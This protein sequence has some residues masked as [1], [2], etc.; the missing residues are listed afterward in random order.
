MP[1]SKIIVLHWLTITVALGGLVP[2]A[3]AQPPPSM[4]AQTPPSAGS[5]Q[6][7][8][9]ARPTVPLGN[10]PWQPSP[11]PLRNSFEQPLTVEQLVELA[12]EV[13]PQVRATREQWH[14]AQHQIMQNYAPADQQYVTGTK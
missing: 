14:A 11:Q 6:L 9:G 10:Q 12:I 8:A 7:P 3:H 5:Q 13:N 1:S 4:G 2:G